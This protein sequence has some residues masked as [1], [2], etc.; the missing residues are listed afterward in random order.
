MEKT[1]NVNREFTEEV[2]VEKKVL[3]KVDVGIFDITPKEI[4]R[5]PTLQMQKYAT[6]LLK[7]CR[8]LRMELDPNLSNT[9]KNTLRTSRYRE[10]VEYITQLEIGHNA[11]LKENE[12]LVIALQDL[13]DH[14]AQKE[15]YF[16]YLDEQIKESNFIT[17]VDE[18]K[19]LQKVANEFDDTIDVEITEP[20][21]A[22]PLCNTVAKKAK[23]GSG[24]TPI[25]TKKG[26]GKYHYVTKKPNKYGN[27]IAGTNRI[28]NGVK[29][30]LEFGHSK[31]PIQC[32]LLADA[33]IDAL[34]LEHPPE[35]GKVSPRNRDES[36]EV[37]EAY[38]AQQAQKEK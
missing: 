29:T 5:M 16:K 22:V 36:K 38:A 4:K 14:L 21:L 15:A 28:L 27:Y 12:E 33:G 1:F 2:M 3:R 35:K 32:A 23:T 19:T 9:R 37:M 13:D 34:E 25:G 6:T 30:K 8:L 11:L 18:A 26:H 31:N 24:G 10:M 7:E 20:I 17:P